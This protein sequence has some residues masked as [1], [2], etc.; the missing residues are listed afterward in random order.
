MELHAISTIWLRELKRFARSRSRIAGSL[1]QP[2]MWLAL[3]GLGLSASVNIGGGSYLAYMAPGIIGM[4]LLFTSIFSGISVIWDKQFGFL[5]EILVAPVSRTSVV[6]GKVAGSATISVLTALAVIAA[7][8][9]LGGIP[10]SSLTVT[11]ILGMLGFMVLISVTFVALGLVIASR[12]NNMEGFQV[13]MTV[14][15]MPLFFLSGAL[16][17]LANAPAWMQVL[18][19]VDPLA[20]GVDGIRSVLGGPAHLPL[21]FD[22]AALVV[23]AVVMIAAASFMFRS[24]S[25]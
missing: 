7:A 4:S 6:L 20:Y 11:A 2:F 8:I 16:F 23:F 25:A 3:L 14:L 9:A 22:G 10:L 12:L 13:I 21:L 15:V 18:A 24:M 1:I 5:K 19:S 17:P